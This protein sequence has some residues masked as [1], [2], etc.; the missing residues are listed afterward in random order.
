VDEIRLLLIDMSPMLRE[1]MRGIVAGR[2]GITVAAEYP[3]VGSLLDV[4]DEHQADVVLFGDDSPGLSSECRELLET[5][6]RVK[7]ML[8]S[9]EG[10]RTTLHELRPYREPLGEV[11]PDE[12]VDVI[13]SSA[14]RQVKEV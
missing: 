11:S 9:A 5:R 8:V 6:P 3:K 13:R 7:L 2:S 4:V 10:R 1:I 14:A 12:L